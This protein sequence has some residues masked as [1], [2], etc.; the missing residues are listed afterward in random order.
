MKQEHQGAFTAMAVI[1]MACRFPGAD[2]YNQFWQNLELGVN[3]ISEIPSQRWEIEKY[4]SA[5]PKHSHKTISKWG[6]FMKG[7]DQFDAHFFGIS[8]READR[9]DPQQRIMLELSWSCIEDSGYS[10][11]QLSGSQVGVFIG[12]C[13][14]DYDQLQHQDQKNIEGHTA[15]GTYTTII[16][17]RISYCFNFHGPSVPVDTA[18]SSSLVAIHQAINSL[19]EE[20]CEMALVGGVNVLCTPTSYTSFSQLGMLSATGKC[21]TFDSSADGYVRGEG[22]GIILLKPLTK[23]L[24]D[25][26][27]IYGVIKGSAVNHGGKA[28]T[29]TSPNV[30]AQ[31]Q[32]LRSA[33][34]KA[35][36]VPNTISYIETHG[37][38]T[39][40]G[41]PIEINGL[42]RSFRQ[43]HQQYEVPLPEKAYCGLGTVKTNIGHLEA[44][45]GIA[46]VIKVL[47]AMKH[48]KLPKIINFEEL[49]PRI[50]L[51]RSPFYIVS[52]TQEWEQL[53]IET[54]EV[55]P[56]R[57]GVSSF[58]FGGVNA[59]IIIEE[60]LTQGQR[61]EAKGKS[62]KRFERALHLLTLSTK[63]ETA[64][65]ELVG[66]YQNYLEERNNDN[67]LADICYTANTGRTH[68]DHR[69]AV[70][71]TNREEL[72]EKFLHYKQGEEIAGIYS[73]ELPKNSTT[74]KIA[75]LFTGQGSQYVNMGRQL[76]QQSSVFR[77]AIDRCDEILGTL[78]QTSLREI[79]YPINEDESN[80][81]RLSQ[82]AYTQP[83][84][85]AVEYA[86]TQL[87]QS[88]GIKP[89]IVM[90]HSVGEYV[91]ATVA[92]IFSLE[93]A[94]KLI[95]TRGKLMQEL[96][97]GGEMVSVMAS[98]S[99]VRTSIT[100]YPEIGIAAI[101]GPQSVVISGE[102]V[103]L[104]AVV[105]SLE[106]AGIQSKKLHV[107]HAFHS[108]LMEPM[109]AEFEAVAKQIT[110]SQPKIPII[111]NVTGIIADN[112][113]ASAKYWVDHVRQPVRFTQGM[114]A[115]HTQ[116]YEIF[117]EIGPKPVLLG[118]GRQCLP[119][120]VG[121]WLPSL[122]PAQIPLPSPFLRRKS[123]DATLLRGEWQQ[124]LSSL[125]KLYTQGA[126]IDWVGFNRDGNCQ[127]VPLPTYPFQRQRYWM[128]TA[129]VDSS[130]E[131]K[132]SILSGN[133]QNDI[134]SLINYL[135]KTANFSESEFELF[136]QIKN[137]LEHN[138]VNQVEE[139][140]KPK[141][142]YELIHSLEKSPQ[143][144]RQLIL[145]NYL[146]KQIASLL[147]LPPSQ[148]PDPEVGF[149]EMG[150]D[151]LL[152]ADLKQRLEKTLLIYMSSTFA[153]NYPNISV[154]SAYILEDLLGYYR[155][156]NQGGKPRINDKTLTEYLL[157]SEQRSE[158]ELEALIIREITE[159]EEL[160]K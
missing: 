72:L 128:K 11:S 156:E 92:G 20:E 16:P 73:G 31:A 158:D 87:W 99:R 66:R 78:H 93:D 13:N 138:F 118:M 133:H 4:Y 58:G 157:D 5:T 10:S 59:H 106:S 90:G 24:K 124:M 23:A 88:W 38:G 155:I 109:L 117:L 55:I 29:L 44:A 71:A 105:S 120:G 76:Y 84:I 89:D 139:L 14:Y 91:A 67:E 28:R 152:A 136:E 45:A 61:Q 42:K 108:A 81:F 149:F 160:L 65:S 70:I 69:L 83:A 3:S 151:S 131:Q 86:L 80:S 60:A 21:K 135:K 35:N 95:A 26:D 43:L 49:N 141:N 57:A 113:I 15:T 56:R 132:K 82:A 101:N 40:L 116:G 6:G 127:K 143:Q 18:C 123:E 77:E 146:Q 12:V 142:D 75:F 147:G 119:E 9:M 53:K 125:G 115:L 148:L 121:V 144:E 98:E 137:V 68:F 96:P 52:E 34:T 8:P 97:P 51:E 64:L 39:P 159:L 140:E 114:E 47:L 130:P 129:V 1:G 122:R 110:Y 85:F 100:P 36:I 145:I 2:N 111:S 41:D 27:R 25:Q 103:T 153:F 150:M 33:Y 37:A 154:L 46:G 63:T 22:A 19:K 107:S 94:L 50:D 104:M 54:G 134:Q 30:Y 74:P 17:N 79:I 7:I 32:V 62:E 102:S 126:K 112:S 48:K